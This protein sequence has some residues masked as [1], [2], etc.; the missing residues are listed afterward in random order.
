MSRAALELELLAEL[1][2]D[3]DGGPV[4]PPTPPPVICPLCSTTAPVYLAMRCGDLVP[5]HWI[6][7]DGEGAGIGVYDDTDAH[8]V[9][10][11]RA[12]ALLVVAGGVA[13]GGGVA[14]GERALVS[15]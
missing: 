15:H 12:I 13:P 6:V 14:L 2:A 9:T 3:D 11:P 10:A 5:R 7:L 1:E 8:G 4:E